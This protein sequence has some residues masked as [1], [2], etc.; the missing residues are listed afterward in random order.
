LGNF[1]GLATSFSSKTS[2]GPNWEIG[3]LSEPLFRTFFMSGEIYCLME[4]LVLLCGI[5]FKNQ[6]AGSTI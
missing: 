1:G 2:T 6:D 3:K 4:K 5:T